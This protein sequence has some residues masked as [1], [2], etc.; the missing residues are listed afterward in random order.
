MH[1]DAR[2]IRTFII[3]G[4]AYF[5]VR[6]WKDMRA[7]YKGKRVPK[8]MTHSYLLGDWCKLYPG[9]DRAANLL[10]THLNLT[11]RKQLIRNIYFIVQVGKVEYCIAVKWEMNLFARCKP[12]GL[13]VWRSIACQNFHGVPMG[14]HLF[15][16]K[17]SIEAEP[18][19]ALL[20][21]G[22]AVRLEPYLGLDIR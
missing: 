21:S 17:I 12:A 13:R 11:Q 8:P 6:L 1:L 5:W 9:D 16:Q 14:D 3:M 4:T 7:L 15:C 10:W 2:D 18:D 20:G 19:R 22:L